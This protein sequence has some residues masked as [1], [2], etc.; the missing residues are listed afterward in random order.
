MID[1]ERVKTLCDEVG[2]DEFDE[3]IELFLEEVDD[4][5]DRLQTAPDLN[6][7]EDDLHF[8]KGSALGLGFRSFSTLCQAGETLSA[9]GKAAEVDLQNILD[10]YAASK[11]HF[12]AEMP[13]MMLG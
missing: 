6:T 3:V 1:W 8:L 12:Q 5:I 13:Q 7:L 2:A 10:N 4:V 9:K 11:Q